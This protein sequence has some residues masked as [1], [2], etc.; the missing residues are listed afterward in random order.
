VVCHETRIAELRFWVV[1]IALRPEHYWS[2][3]DRVRLRGRRCSFVLA[4]LTAVLTA[5]TAAGC[6]QD[7]VADGAPFVR[8]EGRTYV[9]D[10]AA[11]PVPAD[12]LGPVVLP[13]TS[14]RSSEISSC[15]YRPIDGDSSLP[16]GTEFHSIKGL[17]D[18]EQL[19]AEYFGVILRFS[20]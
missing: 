12:Q 7:C 13:V 8:F 16:V 15:G 10:L 1:D 9:A 19:A 11:A 4:F 6:S 18:S 5:S 20:A 3:A 2:M 17:D 14:D